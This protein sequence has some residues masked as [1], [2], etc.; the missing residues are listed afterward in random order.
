MNGLNGMARQEPER[1]DALERAG[2]RVERYGDMYRD[3][4]ERFGGNYMDTGTSA[5]IAR[6]LVCAST[7][8]SYYPCSN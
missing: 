2:F 4:Y 3:L 7:T 8:F 5:K 1:F 6:G